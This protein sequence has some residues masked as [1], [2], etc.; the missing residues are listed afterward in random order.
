VDVPTVIQFLDAS[1]S[2]TFQKAYI[3][4]SPTPSQKIIF[5]FGQ[6]E[7]HRG[8][9]KIANYSLYDFF[10]GQN[11]LHRGYRIFGENLVKGVLICYFENREP[12]AV[13]TMS[14]ASF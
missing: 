11:N 5:A 2:A 8:T 6:K 3:C 12:V 4:T 9:Q 13:A 10:Y 7:P 14:S 1:L